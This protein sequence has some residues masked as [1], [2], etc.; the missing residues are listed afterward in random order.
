MFLTKTYLI[1]FTLFLC[2]TIS[3]NSH[4]SGL[5]IHG[6]VTQ[7]QGSSSNSQLYGSS[8]VS[9]SGLGYMGGLHLFFPMPQIRFYGEYQSFSS[10]SS[11]QQL[12]TFAALV[13]YAFLRPGIFSF[14]T[15]AGYLYTP[16]NL[17]GYTF[18]DLGFN[19]EIPK[20]IFLA[21]RV[22]IDPISDNRF[23]F[24]PVL[25]YLGFHF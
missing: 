5:G 24:Y 19:I 18:V 3:S 16:A 4:A 14:E 23:K 13:N 6:G 25:G 12:S 20:F 9:K 10:T 21:V 15:G 7:L 8:A 2:N 17:G 22:E 11:T 1:I